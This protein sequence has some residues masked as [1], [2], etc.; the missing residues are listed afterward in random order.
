MGTAEA[1]LLVHMPY[2][3]STKA[4]ERFSSRKRNRFLEV[5]SD[6]INL[7]S[8]QSVTGS[9]GRPVVVVPEPSVQL[10]LD[11]ESR[12]YFE[13]LVIGINR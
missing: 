6:K 3:S 7:K 4:N 1:Y 9:T 11:L 8:E 10:F 2:K 12:G 5:L 13:L